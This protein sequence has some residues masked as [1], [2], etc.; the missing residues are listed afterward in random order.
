MKKHILTTWLS[1]TLLIYS[2]ILTAQKNLSEQD[3]KLN[4]HELF[5]KFNFDWV[6]KYSEGLAL[7][8]KKNKMLVINSLGKKQFDFIYDY[9]NLRFIKGYA[10]IKKENSFGLID[11][12]GQVILKP[13]YE[14]VSLPYNGISIVDEKGEKK[15]YHIKTHNF[16]SFGKS[17]IIPTSDTHYLISSEQKYGVI[18]THGKLVIPEEYDRILSYQNY[19]LVKKE[20]KY[21]LVDVNN[22]V[23][24]PIEHPEAYLLPFKGETYLPFFKKG[25]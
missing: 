8:S 22:K 2:S 3:P 1:F 20:D 9:S 25:G 7:A 19:F 4:T 12:K 15:L 11:Q 10:I 23:L 18:D 14:N 6:A 16:I 17:E 13:I 5:Q 24:L 21:G